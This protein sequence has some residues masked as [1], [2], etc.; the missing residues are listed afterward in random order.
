MA[1][2]SEHRQRLVTRY[3]RLA[4]AHRLPGGGLRVFT[5]PWALEKGRG[6]IRPR[7]MRH[8]VDVIAMAVRDEH[9]IEPRARLRQRG[10][11]IGQVSRFTRPGVDQCRRSIPAG[12][13]IG[14][15]AGAGHRSRIVGAD[16]KRREQRGLPDDL[17]VWRSRSPGTAQQ[18]DTS[19]AA[20]PDGHVSLVHDDGHGAT[21]VA[22]TEHPLELAGTLLDV[23]VFDLDMPPLV[24]VTGG[25]RVGSGVLAEN[26]DHTSTL[27]RARPKSQVSSLKSQVSTRKVAI[28]I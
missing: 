12:Q 14:V 11:E 25:L 8:A 20:K 26:V 21:T 7:Q 18:L 6:R 5:G 22:E 1:R 3:H 17:S 16:Q 23:D 13:Q 24:V 9:T 10:I 28:E 15:V 27:Q 2:S 4:I 19:G